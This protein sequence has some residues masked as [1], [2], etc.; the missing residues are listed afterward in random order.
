MR[1]HYLLLFGLVYWACSG[2]AFAQKTL[3]LDAQLGGE[4]AFAEGAHLGV[5]QRP[6]KGHEFLITPFVAPMLRL[7]FN[8]TKGLSIG[9]SGGG[10]GWGYKL[11][12]PRSMSYGSYGGGY[13]GH[14]VS[15]YLDRIPVLFNRT[16]AQFNFKE[17]NSEQE[18]YL[19]SLKIDLFAGGGVNYVR[20][21]CE[22]CNLN[23]G[24]VSPQDTIIFR[25]QP[26]IVRHWGG[27]VTAGAI[28]RM[29]RLGK[30][31]L[32]VTVFLNQG[33]TTMM[34]VPVQYTYN[35]GQ[36]AIKLRVRGSGV[37]ILA[38][39]PIRLKTFKKRIP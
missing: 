29:Y 12:V 7:Q 5:G 34:E 19:Y 8:D 14:A 25:Q 20:G 26:A 17:I 6:F 27:Y 2:E 10:L 23:A 9:Y 22:S 11:Q 37:G 4:Y 28:A 36:G 35:S 30:E 31:R 13:A 38:A 24:L 3:Y 33:L 32:N 1:S 39:I 15:V 21:F 16:L 18:L